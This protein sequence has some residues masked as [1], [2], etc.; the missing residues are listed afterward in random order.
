MSSLIQED[1]ILN[2]GILLFDDVEELDFC[3]PFEVFSAAS[4]VTARMR[5]REQGPFNVFTVAEHARTVTTRGKLL[6]QPHFTFSD[7]PPIDILVVPGGQGTRRE[8]DNTVLLNWITE[9]T[10][11]TRFNTSVCTGSFLL[12]KVGLLERHRATTHWGSLDRLANTFPTVN[13]QRGVRWVDEGNLI[14]AAGVSAGID[15]SLHLVERLLGREG[16]EATAKLME[17]SW[18]EN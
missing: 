11:Q 14:T 10:Q 15:M 17:Y 7:H 6:V 4:V 3:G 2:V 12:G 16:A 1:E 9:V 5:Q 13:V 8:V 18:N